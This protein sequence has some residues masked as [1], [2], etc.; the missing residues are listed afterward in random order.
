MGKAEEGRLRILKS[1]RHFVDDYANSIGHLIGVSPAREPGADLGSIRAPHPP[2]AGA[3]HWGIVTW[4]MSGSIAV[5]PPIAIS[6]P[7]A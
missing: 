4:E 6:S 2:H 7:D 3:G 5:L 1:R